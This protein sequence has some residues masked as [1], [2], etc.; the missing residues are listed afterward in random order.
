MIPRSTPSPS[1]EPQRGRWRPR[2]SAIGLLGAITLLFILTPFLDGLPRG[3][4]IEP[5][6]VSLV[7]LS[8]VPALGGDWRTLLVSLLLLTLALGGEW[9]HQ[10][11]P[12]LLSPLIRLV[13]AMTY[14]A[15]V[16][17]LLL[18]FVLRAPHVDINVLCAGVSGYLLLGFLWIPAYLLVAQVNPGAFFLSAGSKSGTTMDSFLAFY[19]SFATLSTV[20]YGDIVPVSRV[21]RMLAVSE[22]ITGL[23]YVAVFISRLVAVYSSAR[24]SPPETAPAEG[25]QTEPL[26]RG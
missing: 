3:W 2:Y 10:L 22:A 18:R 16:A 24:L 21:A 12:G 1:P 4:A 20:G 17:V 9:T 5:L 8:A 25:P 14:F 15:F 11:R 13:P 26:R 6:V 23:L 19:F 7:M